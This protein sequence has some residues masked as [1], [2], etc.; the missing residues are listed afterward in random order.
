MIVCDKRHGKGNLLQLELKPKDAY[1]TYGK[2]LARLAEGCESREDEQREAETRRILFRLQ[3]G[4]KIFG[5]G[6]F[7][8]HPKPDKYNC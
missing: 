2:C 5:P 6:N 4:V 1:E 8:T 7:E 3:I